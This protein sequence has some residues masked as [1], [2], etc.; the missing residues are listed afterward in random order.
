MQP[1]WNWFEPYECVCPCDQGT[2]NIVN[3]F[4]L[5]FLMKTLIYWTHAMLMVTVLSPRIFF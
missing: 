2:D 3:K 4:R 1:I 5:F